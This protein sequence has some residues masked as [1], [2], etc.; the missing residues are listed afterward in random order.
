M[1]MLTAEHLKR[2]IYG[3]D[4]LRAFAI[5]VI[6]Y[7][8]GSHY[9]SEIIPEHVH[10]LTILDGVPFF[11]MLSGLQIFSLLARDHYRRYNT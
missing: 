10:Q 4:I 8:H 11:F 7:G 5:L 1:K 6:V 3:L 9:L 2:R